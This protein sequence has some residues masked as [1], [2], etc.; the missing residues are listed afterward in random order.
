MKPHFYKLFRKGGRQHVRYHHPVKYIPQ[1]KAYSQS[2]NIPAVTAPV[3]EKIGM[4]S[5]PYLSY[6]LTWNPFTLFRSRKRVFFVQI[7]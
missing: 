6:V 3:C 7:R 2:H 5:C 1:Q 4:V